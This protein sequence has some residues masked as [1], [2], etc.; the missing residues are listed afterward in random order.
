MG[1][2]L[3]TLATL[4]C[5]GRGGSGEGQRE[6]DTESKAGSRL[7]AVSTEPNT[8]IKPMNRE[9]ITRARSQMLN[10]L[11]HPGAPGVEHFKETTMQ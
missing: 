3:R 10:R 4:V 9:I 2:R 5:R 6:G 1:R 7:L 11:S 8:G